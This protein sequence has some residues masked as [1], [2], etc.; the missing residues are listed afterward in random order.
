MFTLSGLG[1]LEVVDYQPGAC[2]IGPAEIGRRRLVGWLGLIAGVLIV[3]ALVAVGAPAWTR[4]FVFVPAGIAASGF[5]QAHFHFCAGFAARG[6]YN[7]GDLGPV[8]RVVSAAD[9]ARDKRRALS[10]N[11]ASLAVGIAAAVTAFLLP[12]G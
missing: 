3:G 10:I 11:L 7:F 6:V 1:P 8:E 9:R 12:L 2:N 4:L 5:L